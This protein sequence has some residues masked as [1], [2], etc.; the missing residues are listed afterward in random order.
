MCFEESQ[1][2][3]H[4]IRIWRK[5]E[6]L[7]RSH[8]LKAEIKKILEERNQQTRQRQNIKIQNF[9][10]SMQSLFNKYVKK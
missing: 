6:K 5:E 10:K 9:F 3:K 2:K 8:Q 1:N 7:G 4:I